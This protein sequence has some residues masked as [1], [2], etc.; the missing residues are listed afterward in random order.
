MAEVLCDFL[1][2]SGSSA[3]S[4]WKNAHL[5]YRRALAWEACCGVH[6]ERITC[7]RRPA[8]QHA[9]SGLH[10]LS[11]HYPRPGWNKREGLHYGGASYQHSKRDSW[12]RPRTTTPRLLGQ[13]WGPRGAAA[14]DL[15]VEDD[16]DHGDG[17]ADGLVPVDVVAEERRPQDQDQDRLEVTQHLHSDTPQPSARLVYY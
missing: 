3:L 7:I 1:L 17:D 13:S 5:L 14:L 2:R 12:A 9:G 15:R 4:T 11:Y 8:A 6:P 10:T 16:A